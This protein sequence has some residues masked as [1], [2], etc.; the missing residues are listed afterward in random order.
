MYYYNG[1]KET[2]PVSKD[3][4]LNEIHFVDYLRSRPK[5]KSRKRVEV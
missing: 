5:T 4:Q 1:N 2:G 3:L